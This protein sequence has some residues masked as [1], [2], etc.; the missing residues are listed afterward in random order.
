MSRTLGQV[1]ILAVS[2]IAASVSIAAAAPPADQLLPG[3]TKGY[4]S[5]GDVDEL[6]EKWDRTQLGQLM[7]DPVM[8]PF[9]D[10]LRRQM[11]EA[12]TKAHRE[13]GIE[14][15]DIKELPTGE[16]TA[17]LVYP[18]GGEPAFAVLVDVTDNRAKADEFLQRVAKLLIE[19]GA[20]RSE[21]EELG[22]KLTVFEFPPS[23][24]SDEPPHTAI[25]FINDEMLCA[26]S[27]LAMTRQLLGNWS[28]EGKDRLADHDP[29]RL[30]MSRCSADANELVP[31]LKWF[32][33]PI[34]Y[35]EAL[36]WTAER[37]GAVED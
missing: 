3:S 36:R 19:D 6:L 8:E 1:W 20:K 12:W 27:S 11:K 28:G 23:E 4:I 2:V 26:T 21:R 30:V 9:A 15:D 37:A 17:A 5:V 25:Y 22:T 14:W 13:L 31:D 10:D 35:A 32:V 16:V 18:P 34:A 29:Y 7:N 24:G 33:E